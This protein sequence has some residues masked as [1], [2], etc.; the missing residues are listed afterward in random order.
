MSP[1]TKPDPFE[2]LVRQLASASQA[3]AEEEKKLQDALT[4]DAAMPVD[5]AGSKASRGRLEPSGRRPQGPAMPEVLFGKG[6]TPVEV[7]SIFKAMH[8]RAGR[9]LATRLKSD[10]F[11]LLLKEYPEARSCI[12]CMAVSAGPP[13]A[14]PASDAPLVALITS[15]ASD[16]RASAESEFFLTE[17]S[18]RCHLFVDM[19]ITGMHGLMSSV[20]EIGKA[21]LCIV[22]S[23][24]DGALAT[25]LGGVYSGPV[26]AVPTS[27]GYGTSFGGVSA[28]LTMLNS[29]SPGITVVNIDNGLGAAAA[30]LRM[31][32]AGR[33]GA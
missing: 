24:M 2:E 7:L 5:S 31:L 17:M 15:G 33:T 23:G 1:R 16:L 25:M 11:D 12:S 3:P 19:G 29:A 9:A 26:I 4:K 32:G 8:E 27:S 28:L 21:S 30:A 18:V 6:K 10:A 22:F 14:P 20:D 13:P